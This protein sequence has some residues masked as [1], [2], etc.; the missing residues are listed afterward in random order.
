MDINAIQDN[1]EELEND[2][3]T[4][5]NVK[6]LA[7][8]YI[9][10]DNL[11]KS[12]Q[13]PGNDKIVEEYT[14]ILPQYHRYVEIKK[15]YQLGN[16]GERAVQTAIKRVCKEVFEFIHTMYICTDM[17]EERDSIRKMIEK[18]SNMI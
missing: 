13:Q 9:V 11:I 17:P 4:V 3:T 10:R 15:E 16:I 8:L 12:L 2:D 14:D 6:E 1:I 7:L 18:L 5:D